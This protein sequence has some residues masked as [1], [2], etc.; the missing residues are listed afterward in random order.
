MFSVQ[1]RLE[2]L[3]L[4]YDKINGAFTFLGGML[5][6]VRAQNHIVESHKALLRQPRRTCAPTNLIGIFLFPAYMVIMI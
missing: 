2:N 5:E 3:N 1:I 6:T 4:F